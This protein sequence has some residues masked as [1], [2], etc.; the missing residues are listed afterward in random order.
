MFSRKPRSRV[1]RSAPRSAR[2]QLETLEARVV[3]AGTWTPL[4][5][6]APNGAGTMMLLPNGGVMMQGGGV[7]NAWYKLTPDAA[8]NYVNGTWSQLA[9]MS[10][11]RLYFGS[12]VLNSDKVLVIGGEYASGKT[13]GGASQSG[14]TGSAEIYNVLTNTWHGIAPSPQGYFGDDPIEVLPNGNVLEG[15]ALSS[16]TEIYNPTTN[17]YSPGANKLNNDQTDEE[18]WVKLPNGDILSYAIFG[19]LGSGQ[20]QAQYYDPTTN[21]W[22]QTGPVPSMRSDNTESELGPGILLQNGLGL[23]IAGGSTGTTALYN[24]QSNSWSPGPNIPNGY[25]ADD[26]P[27]AELPDGQ[28]IFTADVGDT[29]GGQYVPPTEVCD[30][31]PNTNSISVLTPPDQGFL[32]GNP[33]FI[34]RMLMLPNGQL[35][36]S[37]STNQL[38]VYSD[39]SSPPAALLPAV[40]SIALKA[41]NTYTLTGTQLNGS[42][43]GAAYGDDV[44]MMSN[45][46]IVTL[47]DSSGNVNFMT[48][49]NWTNEWVQTGATPESVDFTEPKGLTPGPYLLDVS[50][51]GVNTNNVSAGNSPNTTL[52]VQMGA[53]ADNITVQLDP[54]NPTKVQI[55]ENGTTQLGEFP[56]SE[57]SNIYVL[58]DG[59]TN[60]LTINDDN[61]DPV[62]SGGTLTYDGGG[63]NATLIGPNAGPNGNDWE[64]TGTDTG[65]LNNDI[66]FTNV[67]NLT[68]GTGT[69]T[70]TFQQGG[71]TSGEINGG[72]LP[73]FDTLDLARVGQGIPT[74]LITG[75]L[76]GFA[77]LTGAPS[78]VSG[79]FD[80]I[81]FVET[82]GTHLVVTTPPPATGILVGQPFGFVV[83]VEDGTGTVNPTFSGQIGAIIAPG[84]GPGNGILSGVNVQPAVNGVAT[85]SGLSLDQPGSSSNGTAYELELLSVGLAPAVTPPFD[86]SPSIPTKLVVTSQPRS[87]ITAG[88]SFTFQVS[89]EDTLGFVATSYNANLQVLLFDNPGSNPPISFDVPL[90]NGVGAIT[91]PAGD[92]IKA[93]LGYNFQ[94]TD[95]TDPSTVTLT[96]T[97][98]INVFAGAATQIVLTSEPPATMI[99]GT[100]FGLTALAEDPYNNVDTTFGNGVS[101]AIQTNPGSSTLGGTVNIFAD[102][103]HISFNGLS[104]NKVGTGY[105]LIVSAIGLSPAT[106]TGIAITAGIPVQLAFLSTS[107]PPA[108]APAGS[109]F[110]VVV[111]AG[112]LPRQPGHQLQRQFGDI[113]GG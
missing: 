77:D 45:Y 95:L 71:E 84:T 39:G 10:V 103:G 98:G 26:A 2:L 12:A 113:A 6:Q 11:N 76:H 7:T 15:E 17:T 64:I 89:A 65:T 101:V 74:G 90:T 107:E 46:P 1:Q 85:F 33:A 42:S 94:V 110:A 47:T 43:E 106:T 56:Q 55:L 108:S 3:P 79:S 86:V 105:T 61:G 100:A 81:D 49:S 35:L 32:N 91:I 96:T 36:F 28:V 112:G 51:A 8:G 20:S 19:S 14:F 66:A 97:N 88:Q 87:V 38:Y 63:G 57:F 67:Q 41:G 68:G 23:Q 111:Y 21:A 52:Y 60:T 93:G 92:L 48:T 24:Y 75:T 34:D 109:S 72:P 54:A 73:G 62:P 99:A 53:G 31:N 9:S 30:Y 37:D 5:N 59:G 58:G 27:A 13:S 50:G 18:C 69:N 82:A 29:T 4:V 22:Y 78:A 83:A 102:K 25:T 80:N 70:F 16:G 44:E 40:S 104:L